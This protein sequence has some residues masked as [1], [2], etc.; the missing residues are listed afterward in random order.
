M[1]L[2]YRICDTYRGL[3]VDWRP[4]GSTG[5]WTSVTEGSFLPRQGIPTRSYP[6]G[7]FLGYGKRRIF[8]SADQAI[9]AAKA[10]ARAAGILVFRHSP[11][12]AKLLPALSG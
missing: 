5:A 4:V 7:G 9:V 8:T 10:H 1:K 6:P 11:S 3:S 12:Q 2:E